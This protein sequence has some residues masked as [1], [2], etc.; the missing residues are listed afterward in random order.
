MPVVLSS[1]I[2]TLQYVASPRL[3]LF[4]MIDE[5]IVV[6]DHK[7]DPDKRLAIYSELQQMLIE[8]APMN[9]LVY[10]EQ[11][12]GVSKK[13]KNFGLTPA[14]MYALRDTYIVE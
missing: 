7:V 13:V 6:D 10:N 11:M 1:G 9:F 8:E 2:S 4:S 14:S 3:F 12:A 5:I